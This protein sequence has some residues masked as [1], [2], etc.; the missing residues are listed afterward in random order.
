MKLMSISPAT[1]NKH[2]FKVIL[3][4]SS[5]KQH[6]VQFGAKGYSD[7]TIHKDPE[8]KKRYITRH[9]SR[10]NWEVSGILTAGFWSRW[11]LWNKP[12]FAESLENTLKRFRIKAPKQK[13]GDEQHSK[14]HFSILPL[15]GAVYSI[16]SPKENRSI[17]KVTPKKIKSPRPP[18]SNVG[19]KHSQLYNPDNLVLPLHQGRFQTPTVSE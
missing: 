9:K 17:L 5:D 14:D 3:Q 10:E 12:T 16:D 19:T 13:G 18:L 15:P 4:D 6:T 11:I 8:R 7:F 1:D 2:K